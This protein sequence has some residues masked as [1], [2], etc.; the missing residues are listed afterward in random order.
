MADLI[1]GILSRAYG[2]AILFIYK[3]ARLRV[4]DADRLGGLLQAGGPYLFCLFHGDYLL[5]FPHFRSVGRACIF[6]TRSRRGAILA[7]LIR[8]FGYEPCMIPDGAS[9]A[10]GLA[11]EEMA[12]R[13][14]RGYHAVLAVDGPMGPYQKVKHGPVVLAKMTGCALV[15]LGTAS[16]WRVVLR[17]RWDRYTIPL[18]F[19]RAAIAVGEPLVVPGDADRDRI[20]E[21]RQ[22]LEEALKEVNARARRSLARRAEGNRV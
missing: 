8:F 3:T 20:E 19:S 14:R 4:L 22:R 1:P 18:P 11:L 5:L 12:R 16:A 10:P 13:V 15:P 7:G 17:R 6:T 21:A 9:A 2:L